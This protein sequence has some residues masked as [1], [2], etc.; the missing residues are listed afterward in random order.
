MDNNQQRQQRQQ[1]QH[2]QP[3]KLTEGL[4]RGDLARLVHNEMHIDEYKSKMGND[5]DMVVVSFKIGG[6]DPAIDLVNF[7]EKGYDWVLDADTSAGEMDDGDYV[8]FVEI[9]R[10][11]KV[12]AQIM[13]MMSDLVHLTENEINEWRVRY[14]KDQKDH[15]L[16][17]DN[18]KSMIPS[19]PVDYARRIG[20]DTET[21]DKLKAQ[22]GVKITTKAP[23]NDF[24]ESLRIAA[25]LR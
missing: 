23:V 20:K 15:E 24:T 3:S 18:L 6:K 1:H 10:T 2:H 16:T 19:T 25:G 11:P 5:E 13:E 17:V 9:E 7:I 22:A 4:E 14:Y 21:L 8:V 12:P